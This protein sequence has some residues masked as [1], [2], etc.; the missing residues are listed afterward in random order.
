MNEPRFLTLGV[1]QGKKH[2]KPAMNGLMV[3]VSDFFLCRVCD[4]PNV[5][6]PNDCMA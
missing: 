6:E 1:A 3:V 5:H 4:F 2:S